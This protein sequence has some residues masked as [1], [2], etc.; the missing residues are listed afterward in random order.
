MLPKLDGKFLVIDGP[1]GSGKSTQVHRLAETLRQHGHD[2]VT[3]RDPG[4]TTIGDRI[5]AVV[6]NHDLTEMDATCEALL[7]MASRAQLL[8]EVIRPALDEG[9]VVVCDR[10]VTATCAYQGAAGFD[11]AR[12]IELARL[13]VGLNWPDLTIVLD[14]DPEIGFARMGN[15]DRDAME[16][17]PLE[18]HRRVR[19]LFL[20]C[21]PEYPGRVEIVS[22]EGD[23]EVV[24][25]RVWETVTRALG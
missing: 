24:H 19:S 16:S 7:F 1:D 11:P 20:D 21:A 12:T 15:R 2:V 6:L 18:Y 22:A 5:R 9:K 3:C 17:R 4:G 25:G 23:A 14:V 8:G 10:F 13:V